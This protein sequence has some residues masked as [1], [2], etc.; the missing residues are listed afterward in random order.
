MWN[1]ETWHLFRCM[2]KPNIETPEKRSRDSG[3]RA[4][5]ILSRSLWNRLIFSWQLD[6]DFNILDAF[7]QMEKGWRD[8]MID[9]WMITL[10]RDGCKCYGL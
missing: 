4:F 3:T 10:G 7:G 1:T 5:D 2:Y 6:V 9:G 8:R